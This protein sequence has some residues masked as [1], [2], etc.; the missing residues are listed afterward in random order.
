MKLLTLEVSEI[1]KLVDS[2]EQEVKSL[3]ENILKMCW[4]MRGGLNYNQ[5]MQL[6]KNERDTIN[7]II[8]ENLE[9][10]KKTHLPFF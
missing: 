3:K 5:A 6:D 9:T 4:F 7:K 2:Y 1:E 8:D 10:T